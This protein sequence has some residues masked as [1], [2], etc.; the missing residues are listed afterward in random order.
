[1]NATIMANLQTELCIAVSQIKTAKPA[2]T[3]T[4]HSDNSHGW[5]QVERADALALGLTAADFSKYSY[6]RDGG[7]LFLEEDCDAN[8]FFARYIAKHGALPIIIDKH[9]DGASHIRRYRRIGA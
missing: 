4:F 1:M 8:K 5:L 7:T 9:I 2:Q 3:F 6:I